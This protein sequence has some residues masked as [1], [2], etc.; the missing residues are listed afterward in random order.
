MRRIALRE[1]DRRKDEFLGADPGPRTAA[2][3]LAPIMNSVQLLGAD[4]ATRANARAIIDRQ[5]RH[6]ARLVDDL[7]DVSRITL[8]RINLRRERVSVAQVVSHAVE[9]S[10]PL[11][12]SSG[13]VFN[14]QLP[15]EPLV[16]DADLTR[17]AH[18]VINVLNNAAKYT[19]AGGRIDL[20][21]APVGSEVLIAVADTGVGIP[22]S[23]LPH[24]FEMFAQVDRNLAAAPSGGA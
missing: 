9:A 23:M 8:G 17:L 4:P 21:V 6:M 15:A 1:A 13:H 11:I 10:R 7:L 12:E 16:V 24:I 2:N 19:P 5:V 18:G 3:P 14:V 22:E 20:T